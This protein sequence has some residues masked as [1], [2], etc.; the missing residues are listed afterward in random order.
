MASREFSPEA[1]SKTQIRCAAVKSV[2]P[3]ARCTRSASS[4]VSTKIA[5]ACESDMMWAI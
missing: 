2:I 1:V 3:V 5:T 4:S